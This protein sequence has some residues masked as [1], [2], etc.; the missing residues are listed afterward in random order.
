MHRRLWTALWS[1][2]LIVGEVGV[3]GRI[4]GGAWHD[5]AGTTGPGGPPHRGAR[6]PACAATG[7]PRRLARTWDDPRQGG[8]AGVVV[9]FSPGGSS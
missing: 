8:V 1:C 9:G 6:I 3:D 4:V 7:S 5:A 2:G